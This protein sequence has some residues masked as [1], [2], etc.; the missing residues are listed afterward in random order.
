MEHGFL[1][2]NKKNPRSGESAILIKG[3]T[4][5]RQASKFGFCVFVNALNMYRQIVSRELYCMFNKPPETLTGPEQK[6]KP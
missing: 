4:A 2:V 6:Q 3:S 5:F 1:T